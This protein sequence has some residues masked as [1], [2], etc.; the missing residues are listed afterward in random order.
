M[1]LWTWLSPYQKM[2]PIAQHLLL[3][4]KVTLTPEALVLESQP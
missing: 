4:K 3:V 2:E 1:G